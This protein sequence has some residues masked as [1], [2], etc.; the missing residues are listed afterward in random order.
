LELEGTRN[1]PFQ[2]ISTPLV[3]ISPPSGVEEKCKFHFFFIDNKS[4]KQIKYKFAMNMY[5]K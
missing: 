4:L 2:T 3:S 1:S 5:K